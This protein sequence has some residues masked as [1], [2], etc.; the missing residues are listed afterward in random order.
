MDFHVNTRMLFLCASEFS[1]LNIYCHKNDKHWRKETKNF[2]Y[3]IQFYCKSYSL[4]DSK[5]LFY[6]VSFNS[7]RAAGF[8]SK[9]RK[10]NCVTLCLVL[11]N[12][13]RNIIK[14]RKQLDKF[15]TGNIRKKR[16]KSTYS[17]MY[18][19]HEEYAFMITRKDGL[20]HWTERT[21][22]DSRNVLL[23]T[24]RRL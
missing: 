2:L 18:S 10:I 4:E 12:Y 24:N 11:L 7:W 20:T 23:I 21:M 6:D 13:L 19:V 1:S 17:T 5:M 22:T 16:S 3:R 14:V 9:G 8:W 15:K